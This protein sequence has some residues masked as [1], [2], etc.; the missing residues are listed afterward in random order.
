MFK[1]KFIR[2]LA[3][4]L[5]M[6]GSL[7]PFM[8]SANAR[9]PK[10]MP[11]PEGSYQLARSVFLPEAT[12]DTWFSHYDRLPNDYNQ[13][14]CK[15]MG[16][17]IKDDCPKHGNCSKCPADSNF[18][19]LNSCSADGSQKYRISPNG[20]K[21]EPYC[22][23]KGCDMSQYPMM[24]CP[25]GTACE[26]CTQVNNDCTSKFWYKATSNCISGYCY[27]GGRCQKVQTVDC[28]ASYGPAPEWKDDCPEGYICSEARTYMT[29]DCKTGTCW[30]FKSCDNSKD[31]YLVS[32][33]TGTPRCKHMPCYKTQ[34]NCNDFK[35]TSC[36]ANGTCEK[37]TET[38]Q[39]C[40]EGDT[41]YNLTGCVKGYHLDY[42]KTKCI[43]DCVIG[44]EA[45]NPD[46]MFVDPSY[47]TLNECKAQDGVSSCMQYY[48]YTN[49]SC[50]MA[51]KFIPNA[52]KSGYKLKQE[53]SQK[54]GGT[55]LKITC[56]KDVPQCTPNLCSDYDF[57]TYPDLT[58]CY[59]CKVESCQV[60]NADCSKGITKYKIIEL[61]CPNE[62]M[63]NTETL[64][65]IPGIGSILYNDMTTGVPSEYAKE[66][67]KG[68]V[69]IGVVW[70]PIHT[71]AISLKSY[72]TT[73]A[74]SGPYVT[75]PDIPDLPNTEKGTATWFVDQWLVNKKLQLSNNLSLVDGVGNTKTMLKYM[76]ANPNQYIYVAQLA[77][78]EY[79]WAPGTTEN[80]WY[81]PSVGE[82]FF[83]IEYTVLLQDTLS[84]VGGDP[85]PEISREPD[86]FN[87]AHWS[88]TE[89][90]ENTALTVYSN[91]YPWVGEKDLGYKGNQLN[92]RLF[93]NYSLA[94]YP[95][96]ER[97]VE[98]LEYKKRMWQKKMDISISFCDSDCSECTEYL[99]PQY[100]SREKAALENEIYQ[101][102]KNQCPSNPVDA[103]IAPCPTQGFCENKDGSCSKCTR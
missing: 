83:A 8:H 38:D 32:S 6:A 73:W 66:K 39:Y 91:G 1:P 77:K 54:N 3:C 20:L 67:A 47:A 71:K 14:P 98:R 78:Q 58:G 70:D 46:L 37:C 43:K 92:L 93:I 103:T 53:T 24:T 40:N 57:T 9:S 17:P 72:K 96:C 55:I 30:Q 99:Q 85:L 45:S 59:G 52:C 12:E 44:D 88:S 19:K 68:K 102:N 94:G 82:L 75:Y 25:E 48:F 36:P 27:I 49:T 22:D 21:C 61:T 62:Y 15:K 56:A 64:Q 18:L 81:V 42:N 86:M 23:Y 95:S 80:D 10:S 65:C 87:V 100:C 16:Y 2:F 29:S 60:T 101:H 34:K 28:G 74:K 41:K 79:R 33:S 13:D 90:D 76:D 84:L 35:L 26:T 97:Q 4:S 63:L 89:M 31:Y 11:L 51:P 7:Y 5:I 69:A 50:A